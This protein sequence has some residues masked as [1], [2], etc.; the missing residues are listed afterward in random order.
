MLEN[1][2]IDP[3]RIHTLALAQFRDQE[4][5]HKKVAVASEG[6][7]APEYQILKFVIQRGCKAAVKVAKK[8]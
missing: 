4:L 7:K 1:T 6:E 3:E 8:I 2:D 5:E